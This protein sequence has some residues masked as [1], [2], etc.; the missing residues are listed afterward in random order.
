M[1]TYNM[2]SG[3]MSKKSL[4]SITGFL[5]LFYLFVVCLMA[6]V[7]LSIFNGS[8]YMIIV[9]FL[10]AIGITI[11]NHFLTKEITEKV[12]DEYVPTKNEKARDESQEKIQNHNIFSNSYYS[13]LQFFK[14]P[15]IM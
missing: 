8:K 13:F 5:V 9:S 7:F 2:G 14:D 12:K 3:N 10:G 1:G 15:S 6:T 4:D 11:G